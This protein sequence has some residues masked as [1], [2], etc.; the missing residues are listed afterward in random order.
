MAHDAPPHGPTPDPA[1]PGGSEPPPEAL[2]EPADPWGS[3]G[4]PIS[5]W[6][7]PPAGLPPYDPTGVSYAPPAQAAPVDAPPPSWAVA[8]PEP[9]RP[10]SAAALV[11]ICALTLLA[12]AGWGLGIYLWGRQGQPPAQRPA[13]TAAAPR[14]APSGTPRVDVGTCVVNDGDDKKPELRVAPC[15]I[16]Q[17][18]VLAR[19]D[20]T[21][22]YTAKCKG[23]VKG[24]EYYYF[25]DAADDRHDF[26]LCLR[27]R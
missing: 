16:A 20:G 8:P 21:R 22:D 14:P 13:P 24:Y 5:P 2:G 1:A 3:S 10:R 19:F 26:V 15:R 11:A 27:R 25:F 4:S 23:K 18:E 7:A 6:E 9:R 17:Y 12:V